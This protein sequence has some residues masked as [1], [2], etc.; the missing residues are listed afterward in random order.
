MASAAING[1]G[2][3]SGGGGGRSAPPATTGKPQ[4]A[5]LTAWLA[6]IAG[7]L[8]ALMA[9]LDI[10]IVNSSL[11]EIQGAIGASGTEGAWVS[12]AYLVAEIVIIPL[13]AWL[14]RLLGLRTFL[15]IATTIF[16]L[17]SVMCGIS[18]TLGMMIVGRVGRASPAVR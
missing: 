5:D 15:L 7:T 2:G 12:T 8:G 6:V 10:S 17:F 1:K 4:N 3:S 14:E 9:T 16:T 11:P 13:S 18:T